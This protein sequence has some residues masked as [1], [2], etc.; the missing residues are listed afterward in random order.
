MLEPLQ[1]NILHRYQWFSSKLPLE[2]SIH[3]GMHP[4]RG[5]ILPAFI[6]HLIA[7]SYDSYLTVSAWTYIKV[8]IMRSAFVLAHPLSQQICAL[9]ICLL[10]PF[11]SHNHLWKKHKNR[12]WL[13]TWGEQSTKDS[14]FHSYTRE[15][16][17]LILKLYVTTWQSKYKNGL[18]VN[19]CM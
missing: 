10:I 18:E 1:L 8:L 11:P 4:L 15:I 12:D 2:K 9:P 19:L 6:M 16:E 13:P 17:A 5:F 14:Y 3:Q 7:F